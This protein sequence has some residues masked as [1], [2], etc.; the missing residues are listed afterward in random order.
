MEIIAL[1][2][3]AIL[4]DSSSQCM[5]SGRCITRVV[6]Q[7]HTHV[8]MVPCLYVCMPPPTCC[9]NMAAR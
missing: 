7:I 4:A 6:H 3:V 9:T 5:D 8:D 2:V 1:V